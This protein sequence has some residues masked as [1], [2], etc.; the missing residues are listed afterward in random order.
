MCRQ[1]N[2]SKG[3]FD[4]GTRLRARYCSV[5]GT[6]VV[7][8]PVRHK[9]RTTI[10]TCERVWTEAVFCA[11]SLGYF[12][13]AQGVEP[14]RFGDLDLPLSTSHLITPHGGTLPPAN[15]RPRTAHQWQ[16][17]SAVWLHDQSRL[18]V[19]HVGQRR[20]LAAGNKLAHAARPS[21]KLQVGAPGRIHQSAK[22]QR[23]ALGI[24][25]SG[26]AGRR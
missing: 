3:R 9:T 1:Q 11:E 5:K 21:F 22:Q 24:C 17:L 8:P 25:N 20:A 16:L 23:V 26:V 7:A 12:F 18:S 2:S 14:P 6:R 10:E 19:R 13:E 15:L 4:A